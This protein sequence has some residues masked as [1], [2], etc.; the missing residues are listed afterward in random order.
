MDV[1][2]V[3]RSA[4][5]RSRSGFHSH[6]VLRKKWTSEAKEQGK[7]PDARE[8]SWH[9]N[10]SLRLQN[11][12]L[13]YV[14]QKV[15]PLYLL[16]FRIQ[17]QMKTSNTSRNCDVFQLLCSAQIKHM[18]HLASFRIG[19]SNSFFVA[20]A[21]TLF[22]ST[23]VQAQ[24][25]GYSAELDTMFLDMDEGDPL[26]ALEYHG[27]YNVYANLT[28][29][30]DVVS[31]V[32]SDVDALGNPPMGI[33]APCGCIDPAQTSIV[34]GASNNPAFFAS[35]PEYE[36]DSF[37]TIGMETSQDEGQIPSDVNMGEPSALC[38]GYGIT[39]GSLYITGS[40]D[41]WPANAVAGDDLKVL[42]ARV[43]TCGDFSVQACMQVFV[44]GNQDSANT[45]RIC[46]EPLMVAFQGCTDADA[47]NYNPNATEDDGNCTYQDGIYGCD[48]EC[49]AD[50]DADGICDELEVPGCT[51]DD[52][53]NFDQAATDD[54]DSCFFSGELCDDGNALTY[55]DEIQGCECQGF[56]C[57]EVD[58]CNFSLDGIEDNTLCEYIESFVIEGNA[59]PFSQTLQVYTYTASSTSSTFEWS[60]VGGD[61]LGGNGTNELSVVW[62]VEGPGSVTV[63]ETSA[64]GCEGDAVS[65]IVDVNLSSVEEM[66]DGSLEVFPVPAVDHLQLVW[67]GPTL[68]NAFV[69]MRDAAGR[70]VMV[71]KVSERDVLQ[72]GGLSSGTYTL[73][74]TVPSRG[75]IQRRI[76]IQ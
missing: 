26:E 38:A 50:A 70:I 30:D 31:S 17:I 66:L 65:L 47:C 42:I 52:A 22:T 15:I 33:D 2:P 45:Q 34:V 14:K 19:N 55:E 39:N 10:N 64:G 37:W 67:T 20:I 69:S 7:N 75:S 63:V 29:P 11:S 23:L 56:S 27:V 12:S 21:L 44:G 32:Y 53:C 24:L 41:N 18:K 59:T 68:D 36:Y 16:V 60:I 54:D 9:D 72:L 48:G 71:R 28:N 73:E 35:F 43:T 25:T 51:D 76:M 40:T 74:F 6:S 57:H 8:I 4:K 13:C 5:P 58:A 49:L 62:N 3:D 61:I 1:E 46:P